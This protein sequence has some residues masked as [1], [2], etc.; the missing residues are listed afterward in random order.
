MMRSVDARSR[1]PR[2]LGSA[3]VSSRARLLFLL[4][5]YDA[6]GHRVGDA[7][8]PTLF[9]GLVHGVVSQAGPLGNGGHGLPQGLL[10]EGRGAS[11]LGGQRDHLLPAFLGGLLAPRVVTLEDSGLLAAMAADAGEG[12]K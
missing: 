4:P 5:A 1:A 10:V 7:L 6:V 8:L 9:E 11:G 3:V 2:S 12:V